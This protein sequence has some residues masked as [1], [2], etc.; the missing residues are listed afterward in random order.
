MV[1]GHGGQETAV[2][3]TQGKEEVR[4]G[5]A[6]SQRDGAVMGH[7][8]G[9]QLWYSNRGKAE[10]SKGEMGQ[11]EVHGCMEGWTGSNAATKS[12]LP[13]MSATKRTR[14]S[15]KSGRCCPGLVS[16]SRM[17][18]APSDDSLAASIAG[19]VLHLEHHVFLFTGGSSPQCLRHRVKGTL[20][21]PSWP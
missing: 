1:I 15:T 18:G 20:L 9:Q 13:R 16:P 2:S 10:V 3:Y 5:Q 19:L 21:K 11:Q 6:A 12:P 14:N 17:N 8:V 7:Q 4:L